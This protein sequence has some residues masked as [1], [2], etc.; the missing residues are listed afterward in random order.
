VLKADDE[1]AWLLNQALLLRDRDHGALD[2]DN[3]AEEL[4]EMAALRRGQ[5]VSLLRVAL[6]HMLK[7]RYSKIRRSPRSWR[8]S[9]VNSRVGAHDILDDSQTL[10]NQLPELL[11]KAYR[12]AQPVAGVEM[13][14]EKY[15]WET[16]FPEACPWAADEVLDAEFLPE[17]AHDANGRS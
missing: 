9:L 6:V 11:A 3:L 2:W 15:Q 5:V 14:L 12:G 8:V 1:F 17:Q 13:G 16:L 7:L 10:R 4:E